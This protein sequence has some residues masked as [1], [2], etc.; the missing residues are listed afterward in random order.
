MAKNRLKLNFQLESAEDRAKFVQEY[1]PTLNF[2]PN[3][4]ELETISDYILWGKDSKGKNAQQAGDV[5]IKRWTAD[6]VES[7]DALIETPGFT[8]TSVRPLKEPPARIQ[9]TTFDRNKALQNA[10]DYLVGAYEEL[11]RQI[12]EIELELNYYELFCGRRKLPPRESLISKFTDE[13]QRILN[14]KAIHLSQYQY[15]KLRHL[16]VELRS[17]QYTYSDSF[18]DKIYSHAA[19]ILPVLF[20]ENLYIGDAIGAYPLGLLNQ[21]SLSQKLFPNT[22]WPIPSD[23]TEDELKLISNLLWD[24]MP[25]IYLDFTNDKH[26]LCMYSLRADLRDQ[27]L[28]DPS[29]IYGTAVQILS[30][31][32]YYEDRA[33]LDP[34]Q[35]ELLELKL[36]NISNYDIANQLNKKYNKSY[37]ENYISTIFHQK[38]IPQIADA[39]RQHREIVENIFYPENFK[40]C[41]DCGKVLL[42]TSDNFVRQK[43]SSDGFSP[44][45][46]RCEKLKRS[47]YK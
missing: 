18:S 27:Q 4:Y 9:R 13:E 21:T 32:Q 19:S 25:S 15:L 20:Q 17:Q 47:R 6:P 2:Q 38:I 33:Q 39:A 44:R 29:D 22:R 7:L 45:C 46:K 28:E 14:E 41:K 37:N 24:E 16:L 42:M 43:K 3:E 5:E 35:K 1:L 40:K 12:D 34:L 11:F 23:F 31:L 36:N 8:E 26:I 10:P 30:T